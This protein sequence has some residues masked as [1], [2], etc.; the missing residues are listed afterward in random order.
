[1]FESKIL[2]IVDLC[3]S[4]SL[5]YL[6]KEK[7]PSIQSNLVASNEKFL[8]STNLVQQKIEMWITLIL[9]TFQE[10]ICSSK[11]TCSALTGKKSASLYFH[12]ICDELPPFSSDQVYNNN[13]T[14][15]YNVKNTNTKNSK[16]PENNS[17]NNISNRNIDTKNK[18]WETRTGK[19]SELG[20]NISAS[21]ESNLP[22]NQPNIGESTGGRRKQSLTVPEELKFHPHHS[23]HL[24][25]STSHQHHHHRHQVHRYGQHSRDASPEHSHIHQHCLRQYTPRHHTQQHH[26]RASS[27]GHQQLEHR[28]DE[29]TI[30]ESA[31]PKCKTEPSRSPSPLSTPSPS[32]STSLQF[33]SRPFD[34]QSI[35]SS[36]SSSGVE[37]EFTR[38]CTVSADS[39]LLHPD[40]TGS[41]SD[42]GVTS[43]NLG[44]AMGGGS[45]MGHQY[46]HSSHPSYHHLSETV[47]GSTGT[48]LGRDEAKPM[49]SDSSL[50]AGKG[51]KAGLLLDPGSLVKRKISGSLSS[52]QIHDDLMF[53]DKVTLTP[54]TRSVSPKMI[55]TGKYRRDKNTSTSSPSAS[56]VT[57]K[58][59]N[60]S[61]PLTGS[62]STAGVS[63]PITSQ[64]STSQSPSTSEK[65]KASMANVVL[66]GPGRLARL[67]RRTHSAGCSKD[68][69]SH[70]LFLR[71]KPMKHH[72]TSAP[73]TEGEMGDKRRG[74]KQAPA[75][76]DMKQRLR[77]LRRRHTDSSIQST[78][79]RPTPEEASKWS[80]SFQLLM[81]NKYGATLFKAFLA[82][83]Y[84]QENIEF[85]IACEEFKKVRPA[86]MPS[87][88][89]KIYDDFVA[90]KSPKEINLDPNLRTNIFQSLTA[91]EE[92][93]F[94]IAQRKIQGMLEQD[95]YLRF[96]Q[97]ELYRDLLV[98]NEPKKPDATCKY[99]SGKLSP[100]S[101]L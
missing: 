78:N 73:T 20:E 4:S 50:E 89:R 55:F 98:S 24:L 14:K 56:R 71:E 18:C 36:C 86:K 60:P 82:R 93:T 23:H 3:E 62:P 38:K 7:T 11:D 84:S 40:I 12:Q 52:D 48:C 16:K 39:L 74:R 27:M 80:E 97:S 9:N 6:S 68:V 17:D 30:E 101:H 42:T 33:F 29:G 53:S 90:V 1:M 59:V 66:S 34:D 96:L 44:G 54:G 31:S 13:K 91:P 75:L 2:K 41:S 99:E 79:V 63:I 19:N 25:S 58:Q 76:E 37:L 67:L 92:G 47:S 15:A 100:E 49:S 77:F 5:S 85:W 57:S 81:R 69:P 65:R 51:Y 70:A 45:R 94:D 61:E 28:S 95:A 46:H 88:A 10:S 22:G 72:A 87:K 32:G 26:H 21:L 8:N 64:P 83:E 35:G 43:V